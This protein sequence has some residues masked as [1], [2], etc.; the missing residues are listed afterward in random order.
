LYKIF[1]QILS[2]LILAQ[3]ACS[4]DSLKSAIKNDSLIKP[5]SPLIQNSRFKYIDWNTLDTISA[6]RMLWIPAK[7]FEDIFS[8]INGFYL[9]TMDVGQIQNLTKNQLDYFNIGMLRNGR[10]INDIFDGSVDFNLFS[11][12]EVS[13]IEFLNTNA[14][15]IYPYNTVINNVQKQMFR[16][17][18]YS[19]ISYVQDRYEN[20]FVDLNFHQNISDK[21]NFNAGATKHSCDGKYTNSDFDKW[22]ARFNLNLLFNDHFNFYLNSDYARIQRGLNEGVDPS[23]LTDYSK[24]TLFDISKAIVK[25]PDAYEIKERFDIDFGVLITDKKKRFSFTD[26]RFFVSNSF[27]EYIDDENRPTPNGIYTRENTRWIVY[28]LKLKQN[29]IINLNRLTSINIITE[30]EYNYDLLYS[31]LN[32]M[33]NSN[34]MFLLGNLEFSYKKFTLGGFARAQKYQYYDNSFYF[35]FGIKPAYRFESKDTNFSIL[36]YTSL[37]STRKL[38]T[39]QQ[40]FLLDKYNSQTNY[41][42]EKSNEKLLSFNAGIDL[43]AENLNLSVE[44]YNNK[45]QNYFLSTVFGFSNIDSVYKFS[46]LNARLF[47]KIYKFETELK[48]T[49]NFQ[50]LNHFTPKYNG[51][52]SFS[53]HNTF[54]KN[55]F[56]LKI[57]LTTNFYSDHD[58]LEYYGYY[59]GFSDRLDTFNLSYYTPHLNSNFTLDIFIMGKISTAVFG[60]TFENILNRLYYNTNIYPFMDRGG[61]ANVLSRFNLTWYFLD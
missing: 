2:L 47:Y 40:F 53:F 60:F 15:S 21:I 6:K 4:A 22:L 24:S 1:F 18:P 50:L 30:A 12:N 41:P 56:E 34:R 17:R 36:F 42:I 7:N 43:K 32:S 23:K 52:A 9:R 59:N 57:G 58:G 16:N 54:F 35:D 38:P 55:K 46:G 19:E 8:N 45:L 5:L 44:Y 61:F 28:G 14:N 31:S 37:S 26:F 3:S 48:S 51:S 25:N 39:Y 27:R 29:F 13:E 20:L 11:R 33:S 10:L 49:V